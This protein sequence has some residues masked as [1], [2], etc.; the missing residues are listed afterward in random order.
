MQRS[1]GAV[2]FSMAFI[3][4]SRRRAS[5]CSADDSVLL[6]SAL[7]QAVRFDT[8]EA[9]LRA[10]GR[11]SRGVKSMAMREGDEIADM[12]VVP[13]KRGADDAGGA[14]VVADTVDGAGVDGAEDEDDGQQLVAV[15]R[16]GYGK[17]M[18]TSKFRCQR[19]GA[20][21]CGQRDET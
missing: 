18:R 11:Q 14:A 17:R 3:V 5:L 4:H 2:R 9:Q 15:T 20:Q 21:A 7:G 12:F 19:R 6:C 10:S 8:S 16:D 13:A 1:S